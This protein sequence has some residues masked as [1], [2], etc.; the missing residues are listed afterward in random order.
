[1]TLWVYSNLLQDFISGA[2]CIKIVYIHDYVEIVYDKK[3]QIFEDELHS[4]VYTGEFFNITPTGIQLG[5]LMFQIADIQP[6]LEQFSSKPS[7]L[8]AY[9]Y[10]D[11][12]DLIK[13]HTLYNNREFE[14]LLR[15]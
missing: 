15:L 5:S 6:E 13:K 14:S 11:L 10:E 8:K 9:T 12:R 4:N 1:M 3:S 7:P 2:E